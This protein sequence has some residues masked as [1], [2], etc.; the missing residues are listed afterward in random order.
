MRTFVQKLLSI[1]TS[2]LTYDEQSDFFLKA[3][4]DSDKDNNLDLMMNF[5]MILS[6]YT[7][8]TEL[9]VLVL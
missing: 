5:K 6:F 7:V 2:A 3:K 9:I 8:L 4:L 1:R